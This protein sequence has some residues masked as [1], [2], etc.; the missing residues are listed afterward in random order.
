MFTHVFFVSLQYHANV[1]SIMHVVSKVFV[2]PC[3][4]HEH[5]IHVCYLS[6]VFDE[7]LVSPPMAFAFSV[8]AYSLKDKHDPFRATY[9]II[10]EDEFSCCYRLTFHV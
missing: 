2:V 9:K 6:A 3:H 7:V 10:R 8:F 5:L 4:L 1:I